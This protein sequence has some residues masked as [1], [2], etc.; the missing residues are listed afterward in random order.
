MP[1]R[2]KDFGQENRGFPR[3]RRRPWAAEFAGLGMNCPAFCVADKKA[4]TGKSRGIGGNFSGPALA[5]S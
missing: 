3:F 5:S 2:R 4:L 1:L